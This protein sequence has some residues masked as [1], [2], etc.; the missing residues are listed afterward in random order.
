M[1]RRPRPWPDRDRGLRDPR[2]GLWRFPDGA[3]VILIYD[4]GDDCFGYAGILDWLDVSD[5][6]HAPFGG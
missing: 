1:L 6:G 3:E 5:W 4:P 2:L